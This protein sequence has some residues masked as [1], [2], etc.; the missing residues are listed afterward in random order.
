MH[1]S[2]GELASLIHAV[3]CPTVV[4][5]LAATRN[6]GVHSCGFKAHD[7]YRPSQ[8]TRL[9]PSL[10]SALPRAPAPQADSC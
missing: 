1:M 7:E 10:R 5:G 2:F 4:I 3:A 6:D 8:S 9:P